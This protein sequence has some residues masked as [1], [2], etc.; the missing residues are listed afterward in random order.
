VAEGLQYY[1]CVGPPEVLAAVQPGSEGR[2]IDS[3]DDFAGWLA[4]RS[5]DE[6]AE[7]FTFVIGVNGVLRLAPRCSEHVACA[8][9]APALSAGEITFVHDQ[10]RWAVSE[11]SNQLTGYCPDL[12]SWPA[13]LAALNRAG[14]DHP[15]CFTCP[16]NFR[17]CPQCHERNV[18]K[19][20]HY[21]CAICG[22]ELPRAWNFSQLPGRCD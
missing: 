18:V 3:P 1:R 14:L 15:G 10:G 11:I 5:K 7:P 2:M 19:D 22:G 21:V 17:R 4:T 16:V 9:G 8:G 20:D 13:V 6:L 12:T